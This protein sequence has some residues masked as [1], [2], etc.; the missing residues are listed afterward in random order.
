MF[1]FF[2]QEIGQRQGQGLSHLAQEQ[3]RDVPVAGL[4]L[5]EIALGDPRRGGEHFAA[6]VESRTRIAYAGSQLLQILLLIFVIRH[7]QADDC[8]RLVACI[9]ARTGHGPQ[10]YNVQATPV[11]LLVA[12]QRLVPW[13]AESVSTPQV[14]SSMLAANQRNAHR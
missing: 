6:H 10:H 9:I 14:A 12:D 2:A 11:G 8:N 4:Q 5:G 3:N 1:A 13:P 7:W